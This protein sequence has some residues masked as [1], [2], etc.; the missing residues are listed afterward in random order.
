MVVFVVTLGFSALTSTANAYSLY[1]DNSSN[2]ASA[3][4]GSE[5]TAT[6]QSYSGFNFGQMIDQLVVPFENF[7]NSVGS[8]GSTI[9]TGSSGA[10]FEAPAIP[11]TTQAL[12]AAGQNAF[13]RFDAWLYSIAG[14][15][16]EMVIA[17]ILGV[18][19][20]T[21]G[22]AKEIVDWLLSLVNK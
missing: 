22:I 11:T 15:H 9:G 8:A 19:S 14:F 17:F 21:L 12:N 13:Q 18:V 20:W 3:V 1:P 5:S 7:A 4:G 2:S 10:P 6:A 16:I